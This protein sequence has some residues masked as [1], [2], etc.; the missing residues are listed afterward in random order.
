[1]DSTNTALLILCLILQV[2]ILFLL[3]PA[4]SPYRSL[5]NTAT[6]RVYGGNWA[7]IEKDLLKTPN[8]FNTP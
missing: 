7:K 2:R 5:S 1:M 6:G 8:S 4:A 3:R